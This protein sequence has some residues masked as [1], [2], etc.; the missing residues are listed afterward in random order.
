MQASDHPVFR[1]PSREQ[2]VARRLSLGLQALA[3]HVSDI[4]SP[5]C[6]EYR[7]KQFA[8]PPPAPLLSP[9][10]NLCGRGFDDAWRALRCHLCGFFVCEP[11]SRV[12]ERE[13]ELHRVQFVRCCSPCLDRLNAHCQFVDPDE[14]ADFAAAPWVTASNST[15]QLQAHLADIL[16]S[17]EK[18]RPAVIS[19]LARFG[20][21]VGGIDMMLSDISEEDWTAATTTNHMATIDAIGGAVSGLSSPGSSVQKDPAM[22]WNKMSGA[23]RAQLL[24][25]QCFAVR[26]PEL[27]LDQCLFAEHDGRRAYTLT[28]DDTT[29]IAGA[30]LVP[31]EKRRNAAIGASELLE[32]GF[33]TPE[34]RLVCLLAAKELDALA[35]TIT[36][37]HG[38]RT[39]AL[40]LGED[41]GS[42]SV[43]RQHACCSYASAWMQP[44]LIR[45]TLLDLRFCKFPSILT[46]DGFRFYVSFPLLDAARVPI[47]HL[48]VLDKKPHKTITTAQYSTAQML[49]EVLT[50][51]C[52][53]TS[54]DPGY[55]TW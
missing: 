28:F 25:D 9:N 44:F 53:G 20:R 39:F 27:Q 34:M 37:V 40:S 12:V 31:N 23:E 49:A 43:D 4:D 46:D 6:H 2:L 41:D 15:S 1:R 7:D 10:C 33:F 38:K 16:R 8:L 48:V 26:V 18:L 42:I 13:R 35:G 52:L 14:L 11:C 5:P 21:P 30:P 51:L 3:F 36:V 17:N 47:A 45:H 24:V 29:G 19:L 54:P 22:A 55:P 32:P 50:N